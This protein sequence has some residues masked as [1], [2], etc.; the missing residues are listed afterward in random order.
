MQMPWLGLSREEEGSERF[1]FS[2]PILDTRNVNCPVPIASH[3]LLLLPGLLESY[4]PLLLPPEDT[5]PPTSRWSKHG[6][7]I[8]SDQI[9][10]SPGE[11]PTQCHKLMEP[12]LVVEGWHEKEPH[13]ECKTAI[14]KLNHDVVQ[15]RSMSHGGSNGPGDISLSGFSVE[16][17]LSLWKT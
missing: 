12:L 16:N 2:G 5:H 15:G 13:V 6:P 14:K 10:P 4:L 17:S 8:K 9:I 7:W 1:G 3:A 11:L